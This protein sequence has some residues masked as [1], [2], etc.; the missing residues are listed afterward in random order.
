MTSLA[1]VTN[2]FCRFGDVS[3]VIS[4]YLLGYVGM[5][6]SINYFWLMLVSVTLR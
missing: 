2:D 3:W 4:S 6:L 1:A 5:E